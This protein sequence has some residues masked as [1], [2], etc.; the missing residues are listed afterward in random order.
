MLTELGSDG[1]TMARGTFANVS[2]ALLT[3][4]L[5]FA[6]SL[7]ITH[8]VS[9]G[10]F[11]LFSI[12]WTVVLLAQ[13]PAVLGLD[14]GAIRFVAL[15]AAT[16]DERAAR[17]SVQAALALA[18]AAAGVLTALLAWQAP[19]LALH[20]FHKPQAE[21]LIRIVSLSLPAL[22][23]A[24][25]LVGGLQGLGLMAYAAWLN[26]ARGL[27]NIAI[28]A[29]VLA[30]GLGIQ[31]F[32]WA[33]VATSWATVAVGV[34]FLIR[35]HPSVLV[36]VPSEW[37]IGPLLRFSVPQTL[38]TILLNAILWT[39]TL[40]LG[41]MRTAAEVGVYAIV[42]RL[43]SPAQT[44]STATGQMF[45]PRI[46]VEDGRGDRATL[47]AMLKRVTYWNVAMSL[48]VFAMLLLLAQPLLGV[49]GHAYAKG[50]TALAILAAGQLFNAATG[51]LGQMIN[52]SGR[53]YIT[54]VNNAVVAALNVGGCI[55]LI[56]RYGVT[57]AACSTTAAITLVNLIKLVQVRVIFGLDP[58]T[59]RTVK[60]LLAAALAAAVVAPVAFVPSW[61]SAVVEAVVLGAALIVLYAS[62]FWSFVASVEER[63][64]LRRL[65]RVA[66]VAAAIA[67]VALAAPALLGAA[68]T[69]AKTVTQT[70][71]TWV[72]SG[73]VDLDSVTVTMTPK[74]AGPRVGEDAVHLESGCT[75]R[76]GK[77]DVTTSLADGVKVAF[78]AHDLVVGGGTIRCL[79]KVPVLHQ[80][81]IQ[82][83]GG[84]DI[85][86][87]NLTID[88]G[89]SDATLINSEIFIN[90][91]GRATAP[92]T[93]VVCDS[94]TLGPG[95]AHTVLIQNSIRSGVTNSTLCRGK[96][97]N[98]TLTIGA[99]A[100]DPVD[101]GN[102]LV[103]C[104]DTGTGG[105]GTTTGAKLSLAAKPAVVTFGKAVVLTGSF[106]KAKSRKVTISR[107]PFGKHAFSS[108]KTVQTDATGSWRVA[109]R[110]SISTTYKAVSRSAAS[111][112]I[113]V[114][115][116]AAVTLR[117][118]VVGLAAKAAPAAAVH[119][120]RL[121]LQARRGSRWVDLA[122]GAT[123]AA[124]PSFKL[125]PR[126][127]YRL[128]LAATPGFLA[129]TST[130]LA[131]RP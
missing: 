9:V 100:V 33:A 39:D 16:D 41:R 17:A 31:G 105:T 19:W 12:A 63:R 46:A 73:P 85:T 75:G 1:R 68:P 24:R 65:T 97:A 92:P 83:M 120:R 44:I 53:P 76:I 129:S 11:G 3:T 27:L 23:I 102:T 124:A 5:S 30:V 125:V 14:T 58:F 7:L 66:G 80:D 15:G 96:Y 10:R 59:L 60:P 82:V 22:A 130:P 62:F 6:L 106:G 107:L 42:Q 74:A 116:R 114:R 81:G 86:F 112:A 84:D 91:A 113:L 104:G 35:A 36:P 94:C 32:A 43:L 117:R 47:G 57:G 88:C 48:P 52:M 126:G 54:L 18:T 56:P 49:F 110:P 26:P 103:D 72:C 37:R 64:L 78:G 28:A 61:S 123:G 87:R 51:P 122:A 108:V 21:H 131:V 20:A 34:A 77:L 67:L 101:T 95:A 70:D 79:A 69:P 89:R 50:A 118:T 115:V 13:A 111:P 127:T 38:T 40:L 25:V 2:G 45:A 55:L 119:G 128:V 121:V 8:V 71:K 98:L 29:P 109:V 4:A 99:A 93:D 90:M